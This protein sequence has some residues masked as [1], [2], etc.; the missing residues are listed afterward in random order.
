MAKINFEDKEAVRSSLELDK[1]KLTA[2]NINEI[3]NSVNALYDTGASAIADVF[4]WAIYTDSVSSNLTV[5]TSDTLLLIDGLGA[6]T[7]TSQKPNGFIGDIWGLNQIQAITVGD[8]F[9][10][11]IDLTIASSTSNPTVLTMKLD[12]G[13][14]V[15]P[16][17]VILERDISITKNKPFKIDV[18]F[19]IF[20]LNTFVANGGRIFLSVD[21]GTVSISNR[22]IFIKRDYSPS[23]QSS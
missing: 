18:G 8:S 17:N 2:S 23:L 6:N 13:G 1:N 15:T 12:I 22:S 10:V 7:N 9:D 14:G 21:N 5:N 11:R 20:T 3:K 4:G 19:P 16:T